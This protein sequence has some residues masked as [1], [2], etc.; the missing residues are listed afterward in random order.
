MAYYLN[1]FSPETY[2][3]FERSDRT[4]SGF[5]RRQRHA[6]SRT[7]RGDVFVCYLTKLSRWG[8]SETSNRPIHH[9]VCVSSRAARSNNGCLTNSRICTWYVMM[10]PKITP[11]GQTIVKPTA[12]GTVAKHRR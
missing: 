4:V 8:P 1:L 12:L 5:R 7:R 9:E 3:A 11:S 6:A 10:D 2:V